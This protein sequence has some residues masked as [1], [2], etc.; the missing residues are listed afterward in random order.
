VVV[1]NTA[2]PDDDA[3]GLESGRHFLNLDGSASIPRGADA[4]QSMAEAS[5]AWYAGH[6]SAAQAREF[7]AACEVA[8]APVFVHG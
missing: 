8:P 1:L 5:R 6:T 3:D 7:A 2:D 4:R